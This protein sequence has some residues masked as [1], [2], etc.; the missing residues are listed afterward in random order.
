[1]TLDIPLDSRDFLSVEV[2]VYFLQFASKQSSYGS[3]YWLS[4]HLSE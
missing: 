3:M 2:S 1:M 4:T